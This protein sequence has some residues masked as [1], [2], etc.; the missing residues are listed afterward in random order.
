MAQWFTRFNPVSYFIEVMR[1][2][3]LKGSNIADITPHLLSVLAYA[4]VLN[5]WAVFSYRK[6]T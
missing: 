3:V 5:K 2:V 6:R 1:L 4:L